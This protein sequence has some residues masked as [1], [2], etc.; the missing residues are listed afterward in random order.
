MLLS[1]PNK[2]N[3]MKLKSTLFTVAA[4]IGLATFAT[5]YT[6][7]GGGN[8]GGLWNT[9]ANWGQTDSYPS[10]SS[11]VAIFNGDAEV[12]LNTSSSAGKWT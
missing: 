12:L 7:T 8:D 11:D 10:T 6:W 1:Y 9:P 3:D 2:E 5:N 4:S